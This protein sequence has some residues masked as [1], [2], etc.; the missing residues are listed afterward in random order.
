[1]YDFVRREMEDANLDFR[2]EI[3]DETCNKNYTLNFRR[4]HQ[5]GIRIDKQINRFL[6]SLTATQT[7]LSIKLDIGNLTTIPVSKQVWTGWPENVNDDLSLAQLGIPKEHKLL[8]NRQ[9]N[10]SLFN[11]N[12]P[13]LRL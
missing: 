6:L 7:V 4:K 2:L 9:S 12:V 13:L 11:N 1:M 3:T 8:V 5:A 10:V